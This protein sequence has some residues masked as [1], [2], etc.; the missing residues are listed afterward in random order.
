M[1][2][3]HFSSS[4]SYFSSFS[5][6]SIPGSLT[7][8]YQGYYL[9]FHFSVSIFPFFSQVFYVFILKT[10]FFCCLHYL[11]ILSLNFKYFFLPFLSLK[12][13]YFRIP[14]SFTV[15][16][17]F[18]MIQFLRNS[19]IFSFFVTFVLLLQLHVSSFTKVCSYNF[20]SVSTSFNSFATQFFY[21]TLFTN[22][23]QLL[24]TNIVQLFF[25]LSTGIQTPTRVFSFNMIF[26]LIFIAT[27][28]NFSRIIPDLFHC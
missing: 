1:K 26:G 13:L 19:L 15:F 25:F 24:P 27:E 3:P 22:L 16:F 18:I 14:S 23:F 21:F 9:H 8:F 11:F 20:P 10:I 6:V 4:A 12:L 17:S 7:I 5:F 28:F 2:S